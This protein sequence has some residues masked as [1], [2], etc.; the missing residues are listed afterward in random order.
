MLQEVRADQ[1]QAEVERREQGVQ[2]TSLVVLIGE[3]RADQRRQTKLAQDSLEVLRLTERHAARHA[4]AEERR[5]AIE[6][7]LVEAKISGGRRRYEDAKAFVVAIGRLL[8]KPLG[9][10]LG[11][12]ATFFGGYLLAK[13]TGVLPDTSDDDPQQRKGQETAPQDPATQP[14]QPLQQS[15]EKPP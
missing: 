12:L 13:Q 10:V 4:D 14:P 11:A 7:R 1:R 9:I 5:V 6:E 3:M 15:R 2:I 8:Y